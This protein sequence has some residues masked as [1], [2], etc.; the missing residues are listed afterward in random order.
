ME[1]VTNKLFCADALGSSVGSAALKSP[2]DSSHSKLYSKPKQVDSTGRAQSLPPVSPA[3]DTSV[4]GFKPPP[5]PPTHTS[6]RQQSA[7]P[8]LPSSSA[9]VTKPSPLHYQEKPATEPSSSLSLSQN[10][11]V[12][13]SASSNQKDSRPFPSSGRPKAG[14]RSTLASGEEVGEGEEREN[15]PFW[16]KTFVSME[17]DTK[18]REDQNCKT[19]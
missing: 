6:Y 7:K 15:E 10:S 11:L 9:A 19:Q 8:P 16:D 3:V 1:S 12:H 13:M 2:M 17:T 18:R 5:A 14:L 4:S